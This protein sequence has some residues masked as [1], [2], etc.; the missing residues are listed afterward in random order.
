V[1]EQR[2]GS[3]GPVAGGGPDDGGGTDPR[4]GLAP[5]ERA[6]LE[7]FDRL[8]PQ[9]TLRW[10]YD[11]AVRRLT[12]PPG[13]PGR[14]SPWGGLPADL[15]ERGRS[16]KASER[17]LGDVVRL[18]AQDL[19]EYTDRAVEEERGL[20]EL[21]Q[22]EL[23][24]TTLDAVRF[25]AARIERL[26]SAADPLGMAVGELD[27]TAPDPAAW[28]DHVAGWVARRGEL[29]VVVGELGT[30]GAV[31]AA[32][33]AGVAVDAVDPRGSVVWAALSGPPAVAGSG[34]EVSVS[35]SEVGDH[36]AALPAASRG[37]VLLSGCVDRAG[38]AGKVALVDD[39][40]RVVAPGGL[41]VLL[42]TDQAAWDADLDPSVR[43]LLPGRPLHPEAWLT[44]LGQRGAGASS[45]HDAP[46]GTL[47]A[48]VAEVG[49]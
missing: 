20:A 35:L 29:P 16:T 30:T 7:G 49:R 24:R 46:S 34:P 17:V 5:D 32:A 39:A 33:G 40:L 15:W 43:D 42:V 26:E 48:V 41:V 19:T 44:V 25:L 13:M 28:L 38:L 8:R 23:R 31:A 21:S 6:L 10:N 22:A 18:V 1:T 27:L 45:R 2:D 14:S 37:S 4:A 3:D 36:L 11:D 12:E 9:G 47:H